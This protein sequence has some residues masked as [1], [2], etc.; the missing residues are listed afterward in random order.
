MWELKPS[1]CVKLKLS[2]WISALNQVRR[3]HR[4][5]GLYM[6]LI[7]LVSSFTSCPSERLEQT[8][9]VGWV[10]QA[11]SHLAHHHIHDQSQSGWSYCVCSP[12][13]GAPPCWK[14]RGWARS[15][16]PLAIGTLLWVFL[17]QDGYRRFISNS[18]CFSRI[19]RFM[20]Y[21]MVPQL[22]W[23]VCLMVPVT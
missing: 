7:C 2:S 9:Q 12:H 14:P 18:P 1:G 3:V 21:P 16:C 19:T 6:G 13:L 22:T 10:L 23:Q 15:A 8:A 11:S 4:S 17:F 20:P 5:Q